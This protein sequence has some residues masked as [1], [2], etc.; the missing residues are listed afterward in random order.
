MTLQRTGNAL[1]FEHA[2]LLTMRGDEVL[3]D[4]TLVVRGQ[5]IE[6]IGPSTELAPPADALRIDASSWYLLPGLADMHVHLMP[7]GVGEGAPDEATAL[8]QAAEFLK[9]LLANGVTTARNMAGTPLHLK[10]RRAVRAGEIVGP[11]IHTTGPILETRFTFPELAEFG[12]LVRTREEARAAVL[13]HARAGYDCIKVYNDLD[14]EIYD[15]IVATCRE[16]G[17]QVVGHVAFAKGLDGALAARQDSIE[18]FRSYDFA[19]DTRPGAGRERFVGWL[20]TTPARIR[21]VAERT[22]EAGTWNVPTLIVE[23]SLISDEPLDERL[24]DWLPAWLAKSLSESDLRSVFSAAGLEAIRAG[25]EQRFE[26]LTALDK[27]GAPLMAGSDCPGCA[28]VPGRSLLDELGLY[29]EA[30]LSPLRAL[31]TATIDP[32]KFLGVDRD[33]GTLEP[34]K[35]AD[36]L[37]LRRDPSVDID[38]VRDPEGVVVDG[39][40]HTAASLIQSIHRA[41]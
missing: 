41:H 31:Q 1:A 37:V 21:E 11:R 10:L 22:A 39:A 6:S 34:G 18:H 9:I 8:A 26:L 16:I 14:A 33:L 35:L 25:Q 29:V 20:H 36:I 15:E 3:R 23:R 38:A 24:P 4:H 17:V 19:L 30:G 27:A 2:T 32:A 40:W 13:A 7:L 12:Q 5:R 28:L